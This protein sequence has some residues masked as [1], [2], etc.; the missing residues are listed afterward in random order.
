MT[1]VR[2]D[3]PAW[4]PLSILLLTL[5]WLAGLAAGFLR[6]AYLDHLSPGNTHGW[7]LLFSGWLAI[8]PLVIAGVAMVGRLRWTASIYATLAIPLVCYSLTFGGRS[9]S[10][11]APPAGPPPAPTGR[12]VDFSGGDTRCPGG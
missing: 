1:D 8:G 6:I 9:F 3:R 4:P 2:P 11:P 10:E 7:V 5:V 12:C